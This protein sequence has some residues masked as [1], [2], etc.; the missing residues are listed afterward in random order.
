MKQK[1]KQA[2]QT[3]ICKI[4][5]KNILNNDNFLEM[6][7]FLVGKHTKTYFMHILCFMN[8]VENKIKMNNLVIGLAGRANELLTKTGV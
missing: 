5:H 6:R 2:K 3:K 7:E 4:C 8:R 1:K